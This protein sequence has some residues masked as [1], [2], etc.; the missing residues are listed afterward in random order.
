MGIKRLSAASMAATPENR[1]EYTDA[2]NV[3][4]SPTSAHGVTEACRE[5][6]TTPSEKACVQVASAGAR[7]SVV[8]D[9]FTWVDE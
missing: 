8:L 5:S 6:V 3:R 4:P 7:Q 1:L 2:K 9:R